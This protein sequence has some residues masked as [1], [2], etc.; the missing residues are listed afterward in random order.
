MSED[1]LPLLSTASDDETVGSHHTVFLKIVIKSLK[2]EDL[3]SI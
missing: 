3:I 1:L 2:N